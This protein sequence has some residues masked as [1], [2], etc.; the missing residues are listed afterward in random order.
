[1][2]N[3]AISAGSKSGQ[4]GDGMSEYGF[5]LSEFNELIDQLVQFGA[6]MDQVAEKV[7]DAGSEP[8]R[9]AFEKNVPFDEDTPENKRTYEHARNTVAVTKTK[10]AR[11]S[12]N[13]YRLIEAKTT[14]RDAQGKLVPY[15][16]YVEYGST[17][18]PAK[19]WIEKAYRDAQAAASEP[20]AKAL[21]DE[22]ER[23]LEG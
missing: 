3:T 10:I 8:A 19:P 20:M 16:Y 15:L 21:V 23:Y 4:V 7:L 11:K 5:D 14:K 17:Q 1:M 13:K 22:I 9:R 6:D 12:K 2:T 18:A